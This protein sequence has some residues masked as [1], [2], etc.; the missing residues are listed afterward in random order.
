MI[1]CKLSDWR[2]VPGLAAHPVWAKAL[3]WLETEAPRAAEGRYELGAEGF[4]ALVLAYPHK[5][6]EKAILEAHRH[7]IDIHLTL[8]GAEGI[9]SDLPERLKMTEYNVANEA[10]Y[11]EKPAACATF[12]ANLAGMVTI[13]LPG[14]VHMTGLAVPGFTQVRKVVIKLPARLLQGE[15]QKFPKMETRISSTDEQV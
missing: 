15:P 9:E 8:V 6:R 11:F 1:T 7:T 10:D 14:E 13:I 3:S 2:N 4:A 5:S 12:V